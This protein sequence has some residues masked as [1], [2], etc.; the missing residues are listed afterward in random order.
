MHGIAG[1]AT[2]AEPNDTQ[3]QAQVL[4]IPADGLSVSAL[5]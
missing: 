1:A 2:E 3:P 4:L 5:M